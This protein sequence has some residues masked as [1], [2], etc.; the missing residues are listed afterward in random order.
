MFVQ[1]A[2]VLSSERRVLHRSS[3][4]YMGERTANIFPSVAVRYVGG[5]Q[6]TDLKVLIA[7]GRSLREAVKDLLERGTHFLCVSRVFRRGVFGCGEA[8]PLVECWV[9]LVQEGG[10]LAEEE[11]H[12]M[13][14]KW[15][16]LVYNFYRGIR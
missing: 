3:T 1:I 13:V 11:E 10:G 7:G 16:N 15:F 12:G 14:R 6:S 2:G 5:F 9:T 4:T 8:R